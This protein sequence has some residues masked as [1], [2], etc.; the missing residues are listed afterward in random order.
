MWVAGCAT[1]EEA[2]SM[3]IADQ[4]GVP[5]G[6]TAFRRFACSRPTC[7]ARRWRWR[8]PACIRPTSMERVPPALRELYFRPH[9]DGYAGGARAAQSRRVRAP[10]HAQGRAVHAPRPG[11]LPQR[12]HLP[13][14]RNMQRKA[15]A[16]FHFALKT[17]GVLL[18]GPSEIPGAG[19]R[20]VRRHRRA[21]EAVPQVAR[22]AHRRGR[23][24]RA[25]RCIRSA[26]RARRR[27]ARPVED[28][29]VSRCR[30]LL[31]ERYAPAGAA[32]RRRAAAACTRS[33]A[34]ASSWSP[35]D[36]RPSLNLLDLVDGEL[37]TVL[38]GAIRRAQRIGAPVASTAST[39]HGEGA[40]AG[41]RR[42]A[43]DR[44]QRAGRRRVVDHVRA[45]RDR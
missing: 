12:P 11:E 40:P 6:A 17:N 8:A 38:S 27:T 7:T 3:A 41:A 9:R 45:E 19:R 44:G 5:A 28:A 13:V 35:K 33:A 29:R 30:E 42:R 4:R 31:L 22:R 10:Q 21:L 14:S 39:S 18:L 25:R 36:G 2:Y 15:L 32:G 26:G 1:G 34:P 37:R 23:C 20:R 16:S 43:G 24:A